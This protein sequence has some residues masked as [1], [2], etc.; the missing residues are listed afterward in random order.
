MKARLL[1]LVVAAACALGGAASY[2]TQSHGHAGRPTAAVVIAA[3]G[4]PI[5]AT[6]STD[7]WWDWHKTD[8]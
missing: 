4:E 8:L 2:L 1:V 7:G 6:D 5:D 3:D